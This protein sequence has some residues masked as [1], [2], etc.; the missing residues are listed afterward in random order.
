M[1]SFNSQVYFDFCA[2]IDH[3]LYFLYNKHKV[4]SLKKKIK[5]RIVITCVLK[6]YALKNLKVK[7]LHK[8]NFNKS[9]DFSKKKNTRDGK[10]FV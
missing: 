8:E 1:Y 4:S 10:V 7:I 5:Y 6:T 2:Y 9:E 3:E